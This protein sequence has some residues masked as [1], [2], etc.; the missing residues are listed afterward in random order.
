MIPSTNDIHALI[1]GPWPLGVPDGV[2][3]LYMPFGDE[4][5]DEA[6]QM[7]SLLAACPRQIALLSHE[8]FE[9]DGHAIELP[10]PSERGP[11]GVLYFARPDGSDPGD[12]IVYALIDEAAFRASLTAATDRAAATIAAIDAVAKDLRS[13]VA[14]PSP[15][16]ATMPRR[17]MPAEVLAL[18]SA[19]IT[20]ASNADLATWYMVFSQLRTMSRVREAW[21][22]MGVSEWVR[23][24][25]CDS[26]A[27]GAAHLGI[28]PSRGNGSGGWGEH[29]DA[30][31]PRER[32]SYETDRY[33]QANPD[34]L[35]DRRLVHGREMQWRHDLHAEHMAASA[36]EAM[37]ELLSAPGSGSLMSELDT[38]ELMRPVYGPPQGVR[39]AAPH[40]TAAKRAADLA[41]AVLDSRPRRWK[42]SARERAA[43]AV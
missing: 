4:E 9:E 25:S 36:A 17:A 35:V 27:M 38:D 11:N 28:R 22:D 14:T 18:L 26:I 20:A 39:E 31:S 10:V 2:V 15:A 41:T 1:S 24:A 5:P 32:T 7:E 16:S 40:Q 13:A 23:A 33:E 42:P 12:Y 6:E 8:V 3:T 34:P 29:D 43:R 21:V 30:P 19:G 37:V